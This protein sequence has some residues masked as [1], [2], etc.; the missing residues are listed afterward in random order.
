MPLP[1]TDLGLEYPGP[2]EYNRVEYGKPSISDIRESV[3]VNLHYYAV[4]VRA[5]S[6]K[7][8]YLMTNG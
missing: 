4:V 2:L 8:A 6:H 5:Y 3:P 1:G 7:F